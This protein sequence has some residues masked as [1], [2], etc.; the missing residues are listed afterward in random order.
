M[1]DNRL[2]PVLA[3]NAGSRLER[4][5][6][7]HKSPNTPVAKV[8]PPTNEAVGRLTGP[9]PDRSERAVDWQDRPLTWTG[10]ATLSL[11]RRPLVASA[12]R[13]S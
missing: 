9:L 11:E 3:R 5:E 6:C 7:G 12:P 1:A 13:D 8:V 4:D 10:S 2:G